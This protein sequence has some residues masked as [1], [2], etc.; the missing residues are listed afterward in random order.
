MDLLRLRFK[1][2]PALVACD[3]AAL[4]SKRANKLQ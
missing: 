4:R 1:K 3:G 2:L